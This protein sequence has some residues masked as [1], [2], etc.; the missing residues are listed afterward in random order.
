MRVCIIY[1][2]RRVFKVLGYLPYEESAHTSPVEGSI[3]FLIF[4]RPEDSKLQ[5]VEFDPVNSHK[6]APMM[7]PPS[8]HGLISGTYFERITVHVEAYFDQKH[9]RPQ[10]V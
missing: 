1:I 3:D 10:K 6:K 2:F 7:L 4:F 5:Y 9:S 8:K